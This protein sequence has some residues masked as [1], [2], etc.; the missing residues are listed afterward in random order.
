MTELLTVIAIIGILAAI[1]IP[2]VGK[3]R[4]SARRIQSISNLRQIGLAMNL[5]VSEHR[6]Y[7]PSP[8]DRAVSASFPEGVKGF[9]KALVHS[10]YFSDTAGV[11]E[12]TDSYRTHKALSCPLQKHLH[13]EIT[14]EDTFAMNQLLGWRNGNGLPPAA[15]GAEGP[16]HMPNPS[17]VVLVTHGAPT[18]AGDAFSGV[19]HPISPRP[20]AA[21]NGT[22]I[23]VLFGDGSVR[24]IAL[25]DLP[26]TSNPAL[27]P[28]A[29]AIW[30]GL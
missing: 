26:T 21:V 5:H 16:V 30:R 18:S 14:R 28:A 9:R 24:T 19:F 10:G 4:E 3:V 25:T 29:G 15:H 2:T 11:I 13:P 7:W 8:E 6:G 20:E 1:I 27:N 17:R 12:D 22:S 23:N